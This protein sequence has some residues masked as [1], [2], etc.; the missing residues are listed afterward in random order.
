MDKLM[1]EVYNRW[2]TQLLHWYVAASPPVLENCKSPKLAPYWGGD[3][4]VPPMPRRAGSLI[5]ALLLAPV[6]CGA[7]GL[8]VYRLVR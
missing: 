2:L 8:M 4:P 7:I 5:G 3:Y 1:D 6:M